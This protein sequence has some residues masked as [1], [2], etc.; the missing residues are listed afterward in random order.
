MKSRKGISVLTPPSATKTFMATKKSSILPR[1]FLTA[2]L[3]S[4]FRISGY[5][6]T[7]SSAG[8]KNAAFTNFKIKSFPYAEES[9]IL[10]AATLGHDRKTELPTKKNTKKKG[11]KGRNNSNKHAGEVDSIR[12]NS[13]LK[14]STRKGSSSRGSLSKETGKSRKLVS[15]P[16]RS[17]PSSSTSEKKSPQSL[18]ANTKKSLSKKKKSKFTERRKPISELKLG[19]VFNGCEVVSLR[20]YGAYVKIKGYATKGDGAL[21]HISKI[22]HEKVSDISSV[23]S[24]GQKLDNVKIIKVDAAKGEVGVSIRPARVSVRQSLSDLAQTSIGDMFSGRVTSIEKYGAFIDIGCTSQH[25]LLHKSRISSNER[26]DDVSNVLKVGDMVK[27]RLV[28]VDLDKSTMAVSMLTEKSDTYLDWRK[29]RKSR[30]KETCD[31]TEA[32]AL[33]FVADHFHEVEIESKVDFGG[34]FNSKDDVKNKIKRNQ[35]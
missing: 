23:L 6:L 5:V 31:I 20:P 30:T 21:L 19:T 12:E 7:P 25:A 24:V 13:V 11:K 26:I 1:I 3:L 28:D 29:A 18:T 4:P 16:S 2:A 15:H 10:C 35:D 9:L 17:G 14:S 8:S 27:V 22:R 33:S 32:L 34:L